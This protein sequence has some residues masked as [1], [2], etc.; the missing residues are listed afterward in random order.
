MTE[1]AGDDLIQVHGGKRGEV[2]AFEE[3]VER[4]DRKLFRIVQYLMHNREDAED[5]VQAAFLEAFRH[6]DEFR[7][8]AQFWMRLIRIAMRQT[9]HRAARELSNDH[10]FQEEDHLPIEVADW[11]P[12]PEELYRTPEL[13][14]ILRTA[15][16]GLGPGLRAVFVLRDIEGF[17]VQQTA[18]ALELSLPS[19]KA[20]SLR[21]RLRLR[22]CLSEYFTQAG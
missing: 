1:T 7:E 6:L 19:V 15:L 3:L 9:Q 17:S 22:E 16:Q 21:A 14:E 2:A 4:Y 18:E 20:R 12:N 13:R 8:D 5:V 10:D 11:A